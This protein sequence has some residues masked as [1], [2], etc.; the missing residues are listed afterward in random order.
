MRCLL[1]LWPLLRIVLV[2]SS[3]V[4][5]T[6][7]HTTHVWVRK[8]FILLLFSP[9]NPLTSEK[10]NKR[11]KKRESLMRC[12]SVVEVKKAST[13]MTMTTMMTERVNVKIASR[14]FFPFLLWSD[15]LEKEKFKRKSNSETEDYFDVCWWW[16]SRQA[17][18]GGG[19]LKSAVYNTW[20]R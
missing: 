1:L 8:G 19:E 14:S 6:T 7:S 2:S 18:N 11:I 15:F 17:W 12:V 13:T 9:S 16:C 20:N 10:G 4:C 3:R 5:E